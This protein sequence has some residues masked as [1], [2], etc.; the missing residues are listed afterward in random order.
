MSD[1]KGGKNDMLPN[2]RVMHNPP[3]R[4]DWILPVIVY[5]VRDVFG[6]LVVKKVAVPLS[7]SN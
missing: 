7:T 2:A 6:V 5:D 4:P 1:E 3:P